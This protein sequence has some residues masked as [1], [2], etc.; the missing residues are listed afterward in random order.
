MTIVTDLTIDFFADRDRP[1]NN[2]YSLFEMKTSSAK[3]A[4]LIPYNQFLKS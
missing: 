3:Q 2:F 1:N 4:M